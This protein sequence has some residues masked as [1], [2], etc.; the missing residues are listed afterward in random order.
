MRK[1]VLSLL[2]ALVTIASSGAWAASK[3]SITSAV[4]DFQTNQISIVGVNFG[5]VSPYVTLDGL[6]ATV[7]TFTPT[8][9]L[10]DLPSGI[11]PGSYVLSVKNKSDNLVATFDATIGNAGPQGPQGAQGPQGQTG[12]TGPQG[13]Q[14]PQGPAGQGS[15]IQNSLLFYNVGANMTAQAAAGCGAGGYPI[16]GSCGSAEGLPNSYYIT[17]NGSGLS[18]DQ[19]A[20]ICK[21]VN[22][23][24]FNAH[25]IAYGATCVYPTN[26]PI[27][28]GKAPAPT[29][30][31]AP[32]PKAIE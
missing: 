26:G 27:H 22:T 28:N 24:L 6:V 5:T 23:D 9:I 14:G 2:L 29:V 20:W 31:V 8:T 10:A 3:P 7:V 15:V 17:L 4:A 21:A 19:S 13:P 25:P 30:K 11:A 32:L 1:A 12:A 18:G 16:G